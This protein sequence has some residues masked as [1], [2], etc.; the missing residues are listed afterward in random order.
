MTVSFVGRTDNAVKNHW[1]ST[2]KRKL[3]MGFYAGE[4]IRPNE[5][6]ELLAC[7]NKDVP[8]GQLVGAQLSRMRP[9][10]KFLKL[11]SSFYTVGVELPA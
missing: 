2:I 8:V 4:T 11:L 10:A 3:E 5:L 6:D 1:N 9:H 7:V